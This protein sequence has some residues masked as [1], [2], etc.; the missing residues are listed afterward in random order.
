MRSTLKACAE[1]A[2]A[3]NFYP[4]P[5]RRLPK[6]YHLQFKDPISW[7]YARDV[8]NSIVQAY[9]DYHV[10]PFRPGYALPPTFITLRFKPVFTY[11]RYRY[12]RPS[13]G[14]R[15]LLEG[16]PDE[17]G[18]AMETRMAWNR[19]NGWRFHGPGQLWCWM[20]CD[21]HD[22]NVHH[23]FRGDADSRCNCR[24]LKYS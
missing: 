20:V 18:Y 8:Q 11:G 15:K 17:D 21:M 13:V 14:D 2:K 6:A 9:Q 23:S 3:R 1:S 19:Q 4:N 10:N 16:L 24:T 5:V 7:T 22:W 12:E